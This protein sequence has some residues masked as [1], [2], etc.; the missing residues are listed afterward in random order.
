MIDRI[1][2]SNCTGCFGCYNICPQNAIVME[3]DTEGFDYPKIQDEK[4]IKCNL[5]EKVCPSLNPINNTDRYA[6]VKLYAAWSLDENI[7]L[8]STSGGVFSEIAIEVIKNGGYVCGAKYNGSHLV[9]HVII[10]DI[11]ELPMIRQ[12]KYVQSNV[13]RV[14]RTIKS[15]LQDE[16]QVMFCGTP[17]ECA[18]LVKF[19]GQKY[20]KLILVDFVCRGANSPK[21][22][23]MFL[24]ELESRYQSKV[25][26]VWFK[27]KTY[28][29]NNFCTRIEFEDGQVYLE[30][31]YSDIYIRGYIEANLYMRESCSKCKYKKF[32][33][34]ADI[35]LAD[36]WKVVIKAEGE[37]IDKGTSMVMVNSDKGDAIF[38]KIKKNIFYE[39]KKLDEA[40]IGNP[41][42]FKSAQANPNKEEF[43]NKI[44]EMNIIDNISRFCKIRKHE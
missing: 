14:F 5:C 19:L 28:G 21:V 37:D 23:E 38:S 33:R 40:T 9:E 10:H 2:K 35:T 1:T 7:R 25:K 3:R 26:K 13:G 41:C 30:N 34:V 20:E 16:K 43:W 32:P 42:I 12:S 22:Y 6:E 8:N 15:L 4:C 11:K 44:D 24:N 39:D 27:N 17:C 29:W 36:F 31:R 18:G